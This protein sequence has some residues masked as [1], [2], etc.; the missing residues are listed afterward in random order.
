MRRR[1][2][3]LSYIVVITETP[4]SIKRGTGGDHL[5]HTPP[6][7]SEKELHLKLHSRHQNDLLVCFD[8]SVSNAFMLARVWMARGEFSESQLVALQVAD[9][10]CML[11]CRRPV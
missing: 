2:C 7:I 4:G 9:F 5:P 6:E 11:A 3:T 8:L 10:L 1:N